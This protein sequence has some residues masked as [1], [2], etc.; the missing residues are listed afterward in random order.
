MCCTVSRFKLFSESINP[1]T[2]DDSIV[3]GGVRGSCEVYPAA[4]LAEYL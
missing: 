1:K 4:F 3:L 2:V